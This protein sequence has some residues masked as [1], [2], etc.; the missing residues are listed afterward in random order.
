MFALRRDGVLYYYFHA[1]PVLLATF[2]P[3]EWL[4]LCWPNPTSAL[5]C[6]I[7][8]AEEMWSYNFDTGNMFRVTS[9]ANPPVAMEKESWGVIKG[10]YR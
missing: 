9:F 2:P 5:L 6:A 10:E 4:A 1:E 7:N 3:G 8:S